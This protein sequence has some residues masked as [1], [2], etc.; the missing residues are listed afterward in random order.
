MGGAVYAEAKTTAGFKVMHRRLPPSPLASAVH[1]RAPLR[2]PPTSSWRPAELFTA[3]WR[4]RRESCSPGEEELA[5]AWATTTTGST[6]EVASVGADRRPQPRRFADSCA[7]GD[8]DMRG[9]SVVQAVTQ[10]HAF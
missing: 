1:M 10:R 7:L 8:A 6:L 3:W 5:A 9:V 2:S 4:G